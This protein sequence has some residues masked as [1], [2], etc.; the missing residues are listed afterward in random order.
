M[1]AHWRNVKEVGDLMIGE[2]ATEAPEQ[3]YFSRNRIHEF[4]FQMTTF[5]ESGRVIGYESYDGKQHMRCSYVLDVVI[6]NF[7][8]TGTRYWPESLNNEY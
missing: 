5:V 8:F 4:E 7:C 6:C 1:P 3:Q 2:L